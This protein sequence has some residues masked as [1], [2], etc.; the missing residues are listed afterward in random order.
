MDFAYTVI[1]LTTVLLVVYSLLAKN[2]NVLAD[3]D[4]SIVQRAHQG[5]VSRH[6]G[7]FAILTLCLLF[8]DFQK[9]EYILIPILCFL[10]LFF[11]TL[12]EDIYQNIHPKKR[13]LVIIFSA[14]LA[15]IFVFD[16]F[17]SITIPFT[18]YI[19]TNKY[20]YI[21]FYSFCI[22]VFVNGSNM[23]DGT[24][25]LLVFT[26]ISQLII[27][28]YLAHI[29]NDSETINFLVILFSLLI[30]FLIFNYPFGKIFMGDNG[31]YFFGFIT[32]LILIKIYSLNEI[33]IWS[34]LSI[35]FYPTMEVAFSFF[36]KAKNKGISSMK[37]DSKHL[38]LLVVQ[39]YLNKKLSLLKSNSLV[40][41]TLS[42][43]VFSNIFIIM[44]WD[45][46]TYLILFYYF[47]QIILYLL[48]YSYFYIKVKTT[49]LK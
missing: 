40:I 25:G 18:D 34:A 33:N 46:G 38:H 11:V 42:P 8:F 26:M 22:S 21:L 16:N 15:T 2:K 37:A 36:R 49:D 28:Y 6:G 14:L 39:Y 31:A 23:I 27:L 19:I 7:T 44:I 9:Y 47:L 5:H 35:V 32:G 17:P 10:P 24:N 45:E 29:I 43:I 12:L 13:L 3:Y 30:V 41:V 1:F 48:F 4:S 20:I